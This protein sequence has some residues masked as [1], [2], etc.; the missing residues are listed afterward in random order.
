LEAEA[1][2]QSKVLT[3][4]NKLLR[5]RWASEKCQLEAEWTRKVEALAVENKALKQKLEE[6]N[7]QD[8]EKLRLGHDKLLRQRWATEKCQLEAAWTR[9][10]EALKAEIKALKQKLEE[11]NQQ[12][13]EKLR[14]GHEPEAG[15]LQAKIAYV[16]ERLNVKESWQHIYVKRREV[17]QSF[18][19]QDVLKNTATGWIGQAGFQEEDHGFGCQDV[20]KAVRAYAPDVA[21][22]DVLAFYDGSHLCSEGGP[23]G[24]LLT[25]RAVY[26]K[27]DVAPCVRLPLDAV[28]NLTLNY[29]CLSLADVLCGGKVIAN[30]LVCHGDELQ[31]FCVLLETLCRQIWQ[32]V[33][34]PN[35][36][37]ELKP[38]C[39]MWKYYAEAR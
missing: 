19:R 10:L 24:I 3:A 37:D 13:D 25:C 27:G 18:W 5:Q 26:V 17:D 7:Q 29:S 38:K 16:M 36:E 32:V 12:E 23:L 9:K 31:D 14:L 2:R 34:V 28:Q 33:S 1:A 22:N 4:Q 6:K 21:P 30:D 15:Q 20:L 8:D 11:K 35:Q 39:G